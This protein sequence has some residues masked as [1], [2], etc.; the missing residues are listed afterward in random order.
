MSAS[1]KSQNA[2]RSLLA[3]I[4][5][6]EEKLAPMMQE[7][8]FSLRE[9]RTAKNCSYDRA[10]KILEQMIRDNIAEPVGI[11]RRTS[12]GKQVTAYKLVI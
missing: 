9:I 11:R 7:G 6:A 10:R 5:A 2:L 4:D 1:E 12:G 3:A 8:E